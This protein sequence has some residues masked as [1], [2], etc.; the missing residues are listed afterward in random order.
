MQSSRKR[1]GLE[2]REGDLCWSRS[3]S[4]GRKEKAECH[5]RRGDGLENKEEMR[6]LRGVVYMTK[7]SGPRT[8]PW[9]TRQEEVCQE[10]RSVLHFTRKQRD[11]R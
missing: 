9:G 7:S 3:E 5:L 4:E 8:E 2:H 1:L 6:V 11:D 10:D